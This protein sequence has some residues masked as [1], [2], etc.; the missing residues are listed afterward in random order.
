[1]GTKGLFED[2]TQV[3]VLS[4]DVFSNDKL[5]LWER[6]S[7]TAADYQASYTQLLGV[8]GS[9]TLIIYI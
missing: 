4:Y 1:M 7:V 5:L 2:H 3:T 8:L 9:P 6:V